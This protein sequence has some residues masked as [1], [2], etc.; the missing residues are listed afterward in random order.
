MI[1][2]RIAET[3]RAEPGRRKSVRSARTDAINEAK[4]LLMRRFSIDVAQAFA[5]LVKLA[6]Q[7]N[8]SIEAVARE[9]VSGGN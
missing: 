6:K 1:A 9:L 7:Q 3:L 4:N 8:D 5:L 2:A